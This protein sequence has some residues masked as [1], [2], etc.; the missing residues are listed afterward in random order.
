MSELSTIGPYE[1]LPI[2]LS[3][4]KAP[5]NSPTVSGASVF[6]NDQETNACIVLW[7]AWL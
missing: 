4:T 7:R 5:P 3:N 6:S 1:L 2:L